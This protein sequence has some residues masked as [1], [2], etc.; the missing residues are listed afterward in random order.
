[1]G[2]GNRP[3]PGSR[4]R[5][6]Y[7]GGVLA[8]A[9]A[10]VAS[11]AD[12]RLVKFE[13]TS[14]ESPTFG[15]YSFAG[16]GQY[17]KLVGMAYGELDPNDPKNAVIV[18]IQLAP[19]NASG[20][21]EYSHTFYI[22]KPIELANGN[23]KI[24]Y[25]PPNRGRKLIGGFNRGVGG[26]DP[27]AVTDADA[28]ARSFLM[29]RGY[30]I[31][32]SGWDFSAGTSTANFNSIINLPTARNPDGSSITG[33]SYEY[34][35]MGNAT[36]QTYTLTY[37]AASLDKSKAVLTTRKLLNDVPQVIPSTGWEY[38]SE[39]QIRLLPAGTAF[40]L[41]DI[42]EFSYTAKDPKVNGIGFA[43]VRDF[44]AWLRYRTADDS[45]NANPLA[46]DVRRVYT[47]VLSQP[48]RLLND[49][50]NLG[51][52]QAETGQKV[53]DGHMQWIAAADGLNLN[54]RFS[55][56]A[57]TERNRQDHLY[58]EGIFPFANESTT[59]HITGKTAGRYDKCTATNTCPFAMEIYSANEYWVKAASLFHTDTK[60]AVDLPGHPMARLYLVSSMQHGAGNGNSRGSCQQFLNPLDSAPIQRAL[61]VALENWAE[62]NIAPPDS[63]VPRLADGTLVPPLPQAGM[64]FPPIPGV[65]YNGLMT[66]RYRYDYGPRFDQGIMD[67]NP[68]TAPP[69][70]QNNPLHGPIYNNMIPKTDAD[71]N[72][73]AGVRLPEVRV[74]LNTYTGWALRAA[75]QG[76]NDGCESAGQRVPFPTTK[77]A[78]EASGDPRLSIEERYPNFT[79]YYYKVTEAVNAFV[80]EGFMLAE[81]APETTNRMLNAGFATGAIKMLEADQE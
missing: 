52:N 8:A 70:Y 2:I 55:Q 57:R 32:F 40:N 26:N 74:P 77:A 66:T 80:A 44:V 39:T 5:S 33:P 7:A 47:E 61:F 73:I 48:G 18:D 37:A 68:P 38:V 53:F 3:A 14:K 69:P 12:A 11:A 78:R 36:T 16:V 76:E 17:E 34:F 59:D 21:V 64:G 28:L 51:F 62:R 23:H 6:L 45:G 27:G 56:P 60:G 71:G 19:R 41:A 72:D 15:G 9:V 35:V 65:T 75:G 54:L 20:M 25:E 46:G 58:A 42:Y 50:R 10:L 30:T 4:R 43:A 67:L 31:A 63:R 81:D 79:A 1:M 13:V 49:F 29:P 22:L 24:L